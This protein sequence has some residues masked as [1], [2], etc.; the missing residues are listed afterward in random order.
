M[1]LFFRTNLKRVNKPCQGINN[2]S[3]TVSTEDLNEAKAVLEEVST[4]LGADGIK[5]QENIA[6]ISIVGIGMVT[7]PGVAAKMF[8]VLAE[9]G[10]NIHLIST[11]EIKV[12]CAIDQEQ[13]KLAVNALHAAFELE[14]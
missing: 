10:I 7:K 8:R 5:C 12:S 14:N 3:F 4:Q 6:K 11:S 9:A 1:F 13:G 2:I